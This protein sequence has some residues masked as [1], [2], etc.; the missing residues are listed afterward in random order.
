MINKKDKYILTYNFQPTVNY[1]S[2]LIKLLKETYPKA[3]CSLNYNTTF[4]LLVATILSAQ[5]TDERVNKVTATLFRKY[6]SISDF[7]NASLLELEQDIHSTGF[8][9]NKA[10]NIQ[11]TAQLLIDQ[12]LGQVPQTMEDLVILPGVARKTANVI[13]GNAFG[14]SL[15]IV[16]DTHVSRLSQLLGLTTQTTPEKIEQD[17]MKIIPKADW[18]EISHLLIFHGRQVCKANRPQCQTCP[19]SN[20]CPSS[21]NKPT[22]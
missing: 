6:R 10:K 19:L 7:A 8:F 20:L 16:V 15:G 13:L 4:E 3:E 9:R 21:K 2:E 14:K 17:L 11:A 12:Y 5:C 22:S 18:T 1:V